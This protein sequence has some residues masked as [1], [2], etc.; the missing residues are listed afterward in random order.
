MKIIYHLPYLVETLVETLIRGH[1]TLWNLLYLIYSLVEEH[2]CKV[3]K[4]LNEKS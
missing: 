3:G 2:F 4:K 1:A